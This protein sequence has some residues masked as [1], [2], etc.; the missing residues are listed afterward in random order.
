MARYCVTF[1][2]PEYIEME[3]AYWA[4]GLDPET[5][6]SFYEES[7]K[8]IIENNNDLNQIL[9]SRKLSDV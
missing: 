8:K 3:D 6:F 7:P 4:I 9:K 5:V 2:T 1:D